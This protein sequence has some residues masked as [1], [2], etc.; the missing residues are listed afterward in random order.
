MDEWRQDW[1]D[2][3]SID[4]QTD[5]ERERE[6][7]CS[8]VCFSSVTAKMVLLQKMMRDFLFSFLR[9]RFLFVLWSQTT[10]STVF[11]F[12]FIAKN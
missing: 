10:A 7:L 1:A 6:I 5:R 11:T 3:E 12:I 9:K 2:R 4:R 8:S